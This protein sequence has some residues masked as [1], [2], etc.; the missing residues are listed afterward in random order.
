[1]EFIFTNEK[2]LE[3]TINLLNLYIN[4]NLLPKINI[5]KF[6][7]NIFIND[8]IIHCNSKFKIYKEFENHWVIEIFGGLIEYKEIL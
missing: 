7:D 2:E 5:C 1:M 3:E 8:T 6:K 4:I